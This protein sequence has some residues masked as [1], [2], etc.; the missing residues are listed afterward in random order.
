[1]ISRK[2]LISAMKLPDNEPLTPSSYWIITDTWKQDWE[3]GVQ[4]PVNPDSL[5]AP[6]VEIIDNPP[7]PNFQE[8]KLPKDKYLHLARGCQLLRRKSK[9]LSTTPARPRLLVAMT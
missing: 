1:M 6:K 7:P 8:F 5:P 9:I 4:V 2:D 3:R